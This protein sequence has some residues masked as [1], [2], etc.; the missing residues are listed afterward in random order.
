MAVPYRWWRKGV[1]AK[2]V[3]N[4][5]DQLVA[6][7]RRALAA[8]SC[9]LTTTIHQYSWIPDG[10]ML[11]SEVWQFHGVARVAGTRSAKR[12]A[13]RQTLV[14]PAPASGTPS[15]PTTLSSQAS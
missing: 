13:S 2:W 9:V 15:G 14:T 3:R 10:D 4:H 6:L 11:Y 8:R 1:T 5:I 7:R 12:A